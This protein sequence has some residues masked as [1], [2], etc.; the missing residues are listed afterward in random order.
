VNQ[1][2]RHGHDEAT[3]LDPQRQR[4]VPLDQHGREARQGVGGSAQE[5]AAGHGLE[6]VHDGAVSRQ[7]VFSDG[8]D[9]EQ[10]G[11]EV[12]PGDHLTLNGLVDRLRRHDLIL[13]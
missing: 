8:A 4:L 13:R 2:R 6:T 1:R 10:V 3:A 5:F 9:L 12:A 11:F 7:R